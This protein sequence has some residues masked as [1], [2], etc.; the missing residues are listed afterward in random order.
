M[1]EECFRLKDQ[2]YGHPLPGLHDAAALAIDAK[3]VRNPM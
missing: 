1:I 3:L 2:G